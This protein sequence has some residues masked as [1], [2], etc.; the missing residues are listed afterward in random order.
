MG[1]EKSLREVL[2]PVLDPWRREELLRQVLD[3]EGRGESKITLSLVRENFD[4]IKFS[5]IT[6]LK[7]R[8]LSFWS[9]VET[10]DIVSH[11]RSISFAVCRITQL[12]GVGPDIKETKRI[13]IRIQDGVKTYHHH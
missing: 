7:L 4:E 1:R 3:T 11:D 8:R 5:N 10:I 13:F 12:V 9:H 6:D 2:G